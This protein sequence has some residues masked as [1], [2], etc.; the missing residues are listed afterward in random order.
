MWPPVLRCISAS[1]GL[2]SAVR[3]S[4][5]RAVLSTY[6]ALAC[7]EGVEVGRLAFDYAL[8]SIFRSCPGGGV[9]AILLKCPMGGAKKNVTSTTTGSDCLAALGQGT[10]GVGGASWAQT[11][12][13]AECPPLMPAQ[14]KAVQGPSRCKLWP[15]VVVCHSGVPMY[16]I[17]FLMVSESVGRKEGSAGDSERESGLA[18]SGA[19]NRST[20]RVRFETPAST[21]T[22]RASPP[23]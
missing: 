12:S 4:R 9:I 14:D 17:L 23:C 2:D 22:S 11:L 19:E 3:N 6:E 7:P 13:L 1:A 16:K 20:L 5:L 15:N 10:E 18:C 8:S 21:L